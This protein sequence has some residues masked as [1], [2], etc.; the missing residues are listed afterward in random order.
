MTQL[1]LKAFK[2]R[3]YPTKEQSSFLDRN[4]GAVRF[5]WNQF[6][7]SFNHDFVGPC[8]PQE[9]KFIKDLPGKEFLSEVI[10]YALQQ[11]K[12][13][14]LNLRNNFS[15]KKGQLSWVDPNSRKEEFLMIHLEF[16]VSV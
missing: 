6:V 11:K 4:F 10:S 2:Y 9:E 15:L 16:L 7:A 13:T 14:G 1:V 3:I 5:I 8:M 12:W